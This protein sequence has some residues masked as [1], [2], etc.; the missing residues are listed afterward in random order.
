MNAILH[1]TNPQ[2]NYSISIVSFSNESSPKLFLNKECHFCLACNGFLTETKT[3]T[4]FDVKFYSL[5][6]VYSQKIRMTFNQFCQ[7]CVLGLPYGVMLGSLPL[8]HIVNIL[9]DLFLSCL[10][11]KYEQRQ[12]FNFILC[13]TNISR[14]FNMESPK[15]YLN[16]MISNDTRSSTFFSF[17]FFCI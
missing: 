5:G 3:L 15:Y 11:K 8:F 17:F 6:I 9:K 14:Y 4:K 10:C 13:T 2:R 7:D 16:Q 1:V 12:H